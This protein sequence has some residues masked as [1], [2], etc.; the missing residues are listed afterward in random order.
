MAHSQAFRSI[1]VAILGPVA[2]CTQAFMAQAGQD[3]ALV[4]PTVVKKL[5]LETVYNHSTSG[6]SLIKADRRVLE[7]ISRHA[8]EE[9]R[10][11]GYELVTLSHPL[12]TL[13]SKAEVEGLFS[14]LPEAR[15]K[16][17][18]TQNRTGDVPQ[19]SQAI[20][21]TLT[22]V[23]ADRIKEDITWI[24][25]YPTRY[26]R[27]ETKNVHVDELKKRLAEVAK[28]SSF[29]SV[30]EVIHSGNKTEQKTVRARLLGSQAPNEIVVLGAHFDSIRKGLF[31]GRKPA[32]GADDDASGSSNLIEIFRILSKGPQPQRTIEFMWYA[33]EEV[34][35]VGSAEV[36][37]AYAKEK[38]DVV[39]VLN[40]DMT[41]FPGSG[42][43]A[44][45]VVTDFTSPWLT[46]YIKELNRHYTKAKVIDTE[47]DYA[48]SDHATWHRLGF[49][50]AFP[51]EATFSQSNKNIHTQNDVIDSKSDFNHSAM[52]ARLGLAY[53][54]SLGN[55][56]HRGP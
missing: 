45:G 33:A 3:Y 53:A 8:H 30:E 14:R 9:R 32:P 31:P 36:A 35:L 6:L 11:G 12:N 41:L 52:F 46:N 39:G 55:S 20:A 48:C 13:K 15:Q 7:N 26:H 27:S 56:R 17:S 43:L 23:S 37:G 50:A 47:C 54:M 49:P 40:L 44:F 4:G 38:K 51:S 1:A 42:T 18:K 29:A 24:S 21:D 22:E 25:S 28:A 10:C 2:L 5:N 16:A 34:G 19:F